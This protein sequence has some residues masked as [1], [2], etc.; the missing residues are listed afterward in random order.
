MENPSS[1]SGYSAG[2]PMTQYDPGCGNV[3]MNL[4]TNDV[5]HS[6][7]AYCKVN[8]GMFQSNVFFHFIN[9]KILLVICQIRLI[10]LI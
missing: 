7:G 1:P 9:F 4:V 6:Y 3:G 5:S 2:L 8:H 10:N